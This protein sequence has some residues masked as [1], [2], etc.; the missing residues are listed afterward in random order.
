M[1]PAQHAEA[2]EDAAARYHGPHPAAAITHALLAIAG[3]IEAFGDTLAA[4]L[5]A[6][7]AE[8]P[9]VPEQAITAEMAAAVEDNADLWAGWAPGLWPVHDALDPRRFRWANPLEGP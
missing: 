4:A 9:P 5:L 3:Q 2:A 6:S 7:A 8:H 1:T